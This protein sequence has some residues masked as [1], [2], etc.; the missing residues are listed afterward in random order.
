MNH[1]LTRRRRREHEGPRTIERRHVRVNEVGTDVRTP[2]RSVADLGVPI[3]DAD[4]DTRSSR[5]ATNEAGY[6]RS[7]QRLIDAVRLDHDLVVVDDLSE[8][9]PAEIKSVARGRVSRVRAHLD[10]ASGA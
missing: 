2:T 8:R 9:I 4:L 10:L 3:E 6:D 1:F 7:I 5:T